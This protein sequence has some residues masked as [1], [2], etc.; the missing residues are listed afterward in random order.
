MRQAIATQAGKL[1]P[2]LALGAIINNLHCSIAV[3]LGD[4]IYASP[5]EILV[6]EVHE[7][8]DGQHFSFLCH[9]LKLRGHV[10]KG[11]VTLRVE[12]DALLVSLRIVRRQWLGNKG[13]AEHGQGA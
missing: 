11:A 6:F 1:H 4:G 3:V 7:V 9:C 5:A 10:L 13:P 8:T 2:L 12:L